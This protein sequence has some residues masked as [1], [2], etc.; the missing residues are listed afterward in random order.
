M[1]NARVEFLE[2]NYYHVFNTSFNNEVLFHNDEEFKKFYELLIKYLAMYP[3]IK[4]VSYCI[5]PHHFHIVIKNM[6]TGYNLSEFMRKLQVSYATWYR[7][8]YPS[9]WKHPV[10]LGRFQSLV[11]DEKVFLY[12]TL[13]YVNYLPLKYKLVESIWDYLYTSYHKLTQN[14][15]QAYLEEIVIDLPELEWK[16]KKKNN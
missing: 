10:F 6:E 1:W 7:K 2:N 13:S 16:L 8:R 15:S 12:K 14:T 3:S 9:E 5:V 11:L 4:L